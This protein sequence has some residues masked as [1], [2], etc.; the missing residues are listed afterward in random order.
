MVKELDKAGIPTAHLVNMVPV[1]KDVGSGRI[2]QTVSIPHPFGDPALPEDKQYD[3]RR[4]LV[5]KAL[6]TLTEDVKEQKIF[7]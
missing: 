5:E 4:S 7:Q 6:N 1:A 3:L 2:I